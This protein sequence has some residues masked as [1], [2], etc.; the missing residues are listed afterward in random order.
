MPFDSR[1]GV[2]WAA[3]K[4]TYEPLLSNIRDEGELHNVIMQMIGELNA[5]HTGITGGGEQT[6]RLQTRYPGFDLTPDS[7]GFYKVSHIYRRGP[8]D[9]DY[10]KLAFHGLSDPSRLRN[11]GNR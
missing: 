3:M 10:V 7:S 6:E 1:N 4:D 9:H 8:A 11:R 5:S 2:N